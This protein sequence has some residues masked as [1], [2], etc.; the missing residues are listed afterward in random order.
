MQ[1]TDGR[2]PAIPTVL[3][4]GRLPIR[5]AA[6]VITQTGKTTA[7][8]ASARHRGRHGRCAGERQ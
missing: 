4:I 7:E 6:C 3:I 2:I 5:T 1:T 8:Q